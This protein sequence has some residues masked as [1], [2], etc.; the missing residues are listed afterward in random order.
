MILSERLGGSEPN[1]WAHEGGGS[2][3]VEEHGPPDPLKQRQG[4]IMDGGTRN[5]PCQGCDALPGHGNGGDVSM[6]GVW[7][8][9][10]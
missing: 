8:I 4:P 6:V 10:N 1:T 9:G 5:S 7:R 3:C 2:D